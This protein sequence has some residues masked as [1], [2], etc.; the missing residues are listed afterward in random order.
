MKVETAVTEVTAYPDRARVTVAGACEVTTAVTQLLIDELPLALDPDSVRVSG[1]GTAQ[2]RILGVDVTRQNYTESPAERVQELEKAIEQI[3]DEMRVLA[4]GRAGWEAHAKYLDGLRAATRELAKGFSQGKTTIE[5]Q[6]QLVQFLQKQDAALRTAVR[7]LEIQQR[8]LTK[9]LNK[10]QR[11]LKQIQ[12]ARPRQ[13]Y[14][15]SIEVEVL[16]DGTFQPELT[17]VVG[18]AGWRPLYD[19]RYVEKE[20][21]R[22]LDITAIAQVMQNTGQDWPGVTLA[23]STAR[24][25]LNQRLPELK[26]WFVD[27]YRPPVMQ[28]RKAR[29][30]PMAMRSMEMQGA[31]PPPAAAAPETEAEIYD[32]EEVVA[33]VKEDGGTAVTYVIGGDTHIPSDGSPHKTTIANFPLKPEVD[34]LAVP[35]HTDAVFRRAKVD[36]SSPGPLLTGQAN[37]FVNDEFIGRTTVEY[38][39]VGGEIELLLGAEERIT[40]ERELVRRDVDKRLLSDK[41]QLR[42]GYEIEIK[43]LLDRDVNCEVHDHIPN[44]RHEQIKIKLEQAQPAPAEKSDLNLLEWH[45]SLPAGGEQKIAYEYTVEHPRNLQVVGLLD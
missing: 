19:V 42:Y 14:R 3:H 38:T 22:A 10:L 43:N 37:L 44:S 13:R 7:Q 34:Y 31:M 1:Q 8:D 25:A 21:K 16:A 18:N 39:A 28:A 26:P 12:A 35:K 5:N 11:E 29:A 45:L 20:G 33:E 32:A 24:P 40:I 4:D 30:K 17:Y 23:V 6:T 9:K 2:V 27:V 41:R 15:A 36:N